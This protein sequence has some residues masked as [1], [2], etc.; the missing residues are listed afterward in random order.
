VRPIDAGVCEVVALLNTLPGVRTRASCEGAHGTSS[1]HRH[2]DLAYVLLRYPLPLALQS[3]LV[4]HLDAVAR[5]EHDGV[6]SRWPARNREFL[7]RLL[8]A[9]RAYQA[10]QGAVQPQLRVPLTTLRAHLAR[11][12][13][14]HEPALV[15]L[16]VTCG[17]V[18]IEPHPAAHATI[19]LLHAPKNLAQQWFAEFV[20]RS[21]NDLDP[22][23]I[24]REG[25]E[26][27]ITRSHRGD[28][29]PAFYRRWLRYRSRRLADLTTH[30]LRLGGEAAR[31]QGN[32]I[33]FYFDS[34]H[35]YFAWDLRSASLL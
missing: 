33:D 18:G 20:A 31:R 9:T 6:Y 8:D 28:F 12:L 15:S 5:I 19:P 13:I 3:F 27:V 11:R 34:T 1:T 2:A 35:A 30:Q 22:Q 26:H 14:E 32:Q 7:A 16:C 23:L 4:T 24:E 17:A 25:L 29:G 10:R 21:G